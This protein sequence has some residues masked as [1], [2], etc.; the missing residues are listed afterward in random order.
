MKRT[1][2]I[3]DYLKGIYTLQHERKSLVSTSALAE[4]MAVSAPA[5]SA[6]V[7]KLAS[8]G[9]VRHE[10]Y[11]GRDCLTELVVVHADDEAVRHPGHPLDRLF[12]LFGEDLLAA[13]VD[14]LG[15]PA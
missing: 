5:A 9:L 1:A 15:T 2:A 4:R 8:L 13:R 12:D 3:E 6:M 11:H 10:R 14:D 7:K